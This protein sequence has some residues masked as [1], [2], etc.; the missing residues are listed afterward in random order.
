MESSGNKGESGGKVGE[1]RGNEDGDLEK[2]WGIKGVK[3]V[4]HGEVLLVNCH[5]LAG[6]FL[7]NLVQSEVNPL[8]HEKISRFT[9]HLLDQHWEE[10]RPEISG[11][12]GGKLVT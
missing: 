3:R 6:K 11:K 8:S 7:E 4:D 2:K 12:L 9:L 5:S 1:S 10:L